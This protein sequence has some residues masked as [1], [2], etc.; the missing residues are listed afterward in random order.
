MLNAGI[1]GGWQDDAANVTVVAFA[2]AK[3]TA[4]AGLDYGSHAG[5]R[6]FQATYELHMG[7]DVTARMDAKGNY[8]GPKAKFGLKLFGA[9]D[10]S[11]FYGLGLNVAY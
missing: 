11:P 3:V 9:S 5:I 6:D 7:L 8:T 10:M 1:S 2:D 4:G